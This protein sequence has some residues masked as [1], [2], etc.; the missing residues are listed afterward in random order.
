MNIDWRSEVN[1][2]AGT[3]EDALRR[4]L[5]FVEGRD[6]RKVLVLYEYLDADGDVAQGFD[7]SA[8]TFAEQ[9]WMIENQ[10]HWLIAGPPPDGE[11]DE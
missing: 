5:A 7:A 3:P 6:V 9:L 4:A 11:G 2:T 1:D 8:I 10:R